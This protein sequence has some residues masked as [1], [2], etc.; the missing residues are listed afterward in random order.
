MNGMMSF[1]GFKVT[2]SAFVCSSET[3]VLYNVISWQKVLGKVTKLRK[4]RL[5]LLF[6]SQVVS[7]RRQATRHQGHRMVTALSRCFFVFMETFFHHK[8]IVQLDTKIKTT[9]YCDAVRLKRTFAENSTG[10]CW[11]WIWLQSFFKAHCN[12]FTVRTSD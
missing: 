10:I 11:C 2:S 12:E 1:F 3:A 6:D 7:R 5:W 8:Q 9:F 4:A